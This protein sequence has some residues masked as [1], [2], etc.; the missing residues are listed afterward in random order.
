MLSPN[1]SNGDRSAQLLDTGN[2]VVREAGDEID[3]PGRLLWQSFD[4]P[5]D[6]LLPTMKL[7]VNS[8]TGASRHL[9]SWTSDKDPSPGNYSYKLDIS[10]TLPRLV[11]WDGS[12][13]KFT[14]GL[15]N[16]IRF[17]G[18]PPMNANGVFNST[19]VSS[20]DETYYTD[21]M[22]GN[23][24]FLRVRLDP[25]GR[26]QRS[27]WREE[28]RTWSTMWMAPAH[29]EQF[30]ICGS[31]GTCAEDVFPYCDCLGGFRPRFLKEW[32]VGQGTRG[33]V[34]TTNFSCGSGD[35]FRRVVQVKLPEMDNATVEMDMNLEGCRK[36]CARDCSCTAFASADVRE[37][38]RGCITWSGALMDMRNL[39]G[40]SQEFYLRLA[41]S[42]TD[43]LAS[44]PGKRSKK[45]AIVAS[46]SVTSGVSLLVLCGFCLRKLMSKSKAGGTR[47]ND[48]S[49]LVDG[50]DSELPLFDID[51]ITSATHNFNEKIGEGGFGVVYKGVLESG[52]QIAV[53]RLSSTSLQGIHEFM[54]EVKLIAKLQHKN[55]IRLL[56]CCTQGNEKIL[57][58]DYM[59][60][61]SLD[62]FIFDETRR[63]QLSWRM[64]LNIILGIARG[65]LYLHH[66]SR[67][68]IIHRDLK[69]SNVLL[70]EAWNP[71]ISDFGTARIF[72]ANQHADN[73]KRVIGTYGYMSPEYAINGIISIKSDVFSF[74][75]IALEVLSGV[76]SRGIYEVEPHLNLLSHAWKL[77]QEGNCL[78]LLDHMV[79]SSSH[80]SE[81]SRCIQVGLLCVQEHARDRPTMCEVVTILCS[82]SSSL[83]HP[84]KPAFLVF[85]SPTSTSCNQES[86]STNELTY[87]SIL[88]GR[89]ALV[90]GLR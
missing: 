86:S 90:V 50:E 29:C 79:A 53:K 89:L 17:T 36:K 65:L 27:V 85:S 30:A 3:L 38:G 2:L 11:L 49:K 7:L 1:Y 52:K 25:S 88:E 70:D 21:G 64:R 24:S 68:K 34:R 78:E 75:V 43:S 56:G 77:W 13:I 83:P 84:K 15:W 63:A 40:N 22:I 19:V 16:G 33:C 72:G 28:T 80:E 8:R 76:R 59:Q 82:E 69:A 60:K 4:E 9:T 23:S 18:F 41:A 32:S 12:T 10:N 39:S 74:G 5:G 55:L 57:I 37:G 51:T 6:T 45:L 67:L 61:K 26:I 66:D 73:T 62:L 71:K 35:T 20:G 81:L 48:K 42:D 46:V 47:K 54:N 44:D 31:F 14:T 87:T 58:F